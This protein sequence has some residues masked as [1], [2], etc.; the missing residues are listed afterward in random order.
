MQHFLSAQVLPVPGVVCFINFTL[1]VFPINYGGIF[2]YANSNLIWSI[3][4]VTQRIR[5]DNHSERLAIDRRTG[6]R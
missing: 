2:L 4:P 1:G 3:L 5:R 6:Y